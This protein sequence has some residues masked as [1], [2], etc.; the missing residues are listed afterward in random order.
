MEIKEHRAITP[1]ELAQDWV[2]IS[3]DGNRWYIGK[4]TDEAREVPGSAGTRV[5][6]AAVEPAYGYLVAVETL[7]D[8][9]IKVHREVNPIL[10][11]AGQVRQEFYGTYQIIR[12]SCL[13]DAEREQIVTLI[14]QAEKQRAQMLQAHARKPLTAVK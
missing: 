2:L 8:D 9:R 12:C 14:G 4:L 3:Q 5:I 11:I 6:G 10:T 1:D 13:C 7:K